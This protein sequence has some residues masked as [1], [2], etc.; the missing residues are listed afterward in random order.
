VALMLLI[1]VISLLGCLFLTYQKRVIKRF[2]KIIPESHLNQQKI[3]N[4]YAARIQHALFLKK[5]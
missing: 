4:P 2:F 3:K 1:V 5:I